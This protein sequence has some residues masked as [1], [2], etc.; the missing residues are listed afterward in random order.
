MLTKDRLR[1]EHRHQRVN[2]LGIGRNSGRRLDIISDGNQDR[3]RE[4]TYHA[5][6]RRLRGFSATLPER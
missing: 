3:T 2:Q 4:R 5:E 1:E 6:P